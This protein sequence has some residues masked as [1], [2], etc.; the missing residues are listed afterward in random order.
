MLSTEPGAGQLDTITRNEKLPMPA[1]QAD[2]LVQWLGDHQPSHSDYVDVPTPE[3]GAI[4]GT[5]DV[6]DN[7]PSGGLKFVLESLIDAKL[8][9]RQNVAGPVRAR[10]T[11]PGWQRVEELRHQ[12]T[13]SRLAFMAMSFGDP[14]VRAAYRECF[15][16][17]VA[18]TGF[19]L[20]TVNDPSEA[21]LIDLRIEVGIRR[22]K[23]L[24]GGNNGAYWEAGFGHGLGKKIFYTCEKAFFKNQK[25]HFDTS[26]HHIVVWEKTN[27][28]AAKDDL[29]MVIRAT[30]PKDAKQD[31]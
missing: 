9:E 17:A 1:E 12:I 29:K 24:T 31:D 6:G 10:L 19:E 20:R 3:I 30:L 28:A 18:A 22:A 2:S 26:H 5:G 8:V 23:F 13:N 25:P 4:I 21:G 16:P 7:S 15:Q 27:L 14:V 11:F